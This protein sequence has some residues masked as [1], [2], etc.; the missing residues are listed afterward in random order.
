MLVR[1]GKG[2]WDDLHIAAKLRVDKTCRCTVFES[3]DWGEGAAG[4]KVFG[5][6][7]VF[8][9]RVS[10]SIQAGACVM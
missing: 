7:T 8:E 2:E 9:V 6:S 4:R 5:G 3:V 1:R 10:V